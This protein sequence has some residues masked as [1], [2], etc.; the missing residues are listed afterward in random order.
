[1]FRPR[2]PFVL[3][4]SQPA[5]QGLPRVWRQPARVRLPVAREY[6][7]A[8]HAPH[9]AIAA[10]RLVA[11][12]SGY[13][14]L[15]ALCPRARSTHLAYQNRWWSDYN[16]QYGWLSRPTGPHSGPTHLLPF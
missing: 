1:M 5:G 4:C 14:S 11:I 9:T 12:G 13:S 3:Q 15:T 7:A 8:M 16:W 10:L 2:G 6:L